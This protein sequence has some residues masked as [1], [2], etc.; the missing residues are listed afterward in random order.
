MG[1][2]AG[3]KKGPTREPVL[4]FRQ[5]P[6]GLVIRWRDC[7]SEDADVAVLRLG[8]GPD[9]EIVVAPDAS[10]PDGPSIGSVHCTIVCTDDR[11]VVRDVEAAGPTWVNEV[12]VFHGQVEVRPGNLI[13][14]GTAQVIVYGKSTRQSPDITAPDIPTLIAKTRMLYAKSPAQAKALGVPRRTYYNWLDNGRF[15]KGAATF[16]GLAAALLV[17]TQVGST[18]KSQER[19]APMTQ[20]TGQEQPVSTA[21]AISTQPASRA[22]PPTRLSDFGS[23]QCAEPPMPDGLE[24]PAHSTRTPD[25]AHDPLAVRKRR[26]SRKTTATSRPVP[27]GTMADPET[28]P[29]NASGENA[30]PITQ[31]KRRFIGG[32]FS[33]KRDFVGGFH[34]YERPRR[35]DDPVAGK[36][37]P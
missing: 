27:T 35:E 16:I 36:D 5:W 32:S 12:R 7:K 11:V 25:D 1:K 20:E 19:V 26:R 2:R 4:A 15:M 22:T 30:K 8:T 29:S 13:T 33:S 14:V 10:Y 24:R 28:A 18:S 21:A 17:W 34:E 31:D 6:D 9:N 3:T 37:L 23:R